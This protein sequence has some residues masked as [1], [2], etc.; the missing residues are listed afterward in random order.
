MYDFPALLTP[1]VYSKY[2]RMLFSCRSW[3]YSQNNHQN[4]LYLTPKPSKWL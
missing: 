1:H 4:V 2:T 3:E